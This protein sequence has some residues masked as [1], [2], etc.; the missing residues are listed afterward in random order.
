MNMTDARKVI[1][2]HN[3]LRKKIE[4]LRDRLWHEPISGKGFKLCQQKLK[5]AEQELADNAPAH[6]QALK[7]H[8]CA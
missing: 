6:R 2:K 8:L 1:I 5:E 4:R 3:K 7:A